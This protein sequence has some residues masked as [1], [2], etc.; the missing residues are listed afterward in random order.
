[1]ILR[2]TSKRHHQPFPCGS[3]GWAA[4]RSRAVALG[5]QPSAQTGTWIYLNWLPPPLTEKNKKMAVRREL[6][7]GGAPRRRRQ[8]HAFLNWP[9]NQTHLKR[10]NESAAKTGFALTRLQRPVFYRRVLLSSFLFLLCLRVFLFRSAILCEIRT[11]PP[12]CVAAQS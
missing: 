10:K 7:C 2:L 8:A 5:H 3:L 9:T 11:N 12:L 4:L 1:M 6:V